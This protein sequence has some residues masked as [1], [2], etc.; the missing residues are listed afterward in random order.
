MLDQCDG[1]SKFQKLLKILGKY[2]K[3]FKNVLLHN[4]SYLESIIVFYCKSRGCFKLEIFIVIRFAIVLREQNEI[5]ALQRSY[6]TINPR[7]R[8][9]NSFFLADRDDEVSTERRRVHCAT[10]RTIWHISGTS[11]LRL[12][13]GSSDRGIELA[14]ERPRQV[15]SDEAFLYGVSEL[16][17]RSI[18]AEDA[19][20]R[21]DCILPADAAIHF[22]G[23]KS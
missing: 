22:A 6:V 11:I 4:N 21:A 7:S 10:G 14:V 23:E 3:V 1:E 19:P 17:L 2:S 15:H 13:T 16:Q 12:R 20:F 8:I 9:Q 18:P 5:C